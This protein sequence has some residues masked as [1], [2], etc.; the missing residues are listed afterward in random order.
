MTGILEATLFPGCAEGLAGARARPNRSVGGPSCELKCIRP[1]PDPSEEVALLVSGEVG[2][3]DELDVPLVNVSRWDGAVCDEL[4]E[5]GGGEVVM[6]VVVDT[7]HSFSHG[8]SLEH[9][10]QRVPCGDSCR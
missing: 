3:L 4:A 8:R 9:H 1:S 2:R 10:T 6:L 5:P 7:A